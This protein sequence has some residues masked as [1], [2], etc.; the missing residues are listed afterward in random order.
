[1]DDGPLNG[2][3]EDEMKWSHHLCVLVEPFGCIAK[4]YIV[5][6]VSEEN[7]VDTAN[8][9][10]R[11]IFD[12]LDDDSFH[13]VDDKRFDPF[14]FGSSDRFSHGFGKRHVSNSAATASVALLLLQYLI[15]VP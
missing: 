10:K 8:R 14:K 15:S 9:Q 3:G 12:R 11:D 1:V 2:H 6:G 5:L 4:W 13:Q 7:N